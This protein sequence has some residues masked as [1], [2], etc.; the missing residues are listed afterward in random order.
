MWPQLQTRQ[1]QRV[2]T[3]E[4]AELHGEVVDF[5][6]LLRVG[7]SVR[8]D[9]FAGLIIQDAVLSKARRELIRTIGI[10][11]RVLLRRIKHI[12]Y[13][14][15]Q[16]ASSRIN[17]S[18]QVSDMADMCTMKPKPNNTIHLCPAHFRKGLRI[19][20][21]QIALPPCSVKNHTQ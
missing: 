15:Y 16:K 7:W 4:R 21:K 19:H 13:T 14:I 17:S 2:K 8:L 10:L 18:I 20:H 3:A 6:Y 9:V 5:Q 12:Q 11:K 1:W